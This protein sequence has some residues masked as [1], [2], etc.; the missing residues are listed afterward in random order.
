MYLMEE[1]IMLCITRKEF[2][3]MPFDELMEKAVNECDHI[4]SYNDLLE[5]A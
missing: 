4:H 2:D 1:I 5:F 3:E